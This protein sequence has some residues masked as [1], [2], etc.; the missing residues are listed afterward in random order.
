MARTFAKLTALGDGGQ[1]PNTTTEIE[2]P[3]MPESLELAREAAYK[4]VAPLNLPDGVHIYQSVNP[5][6]IPFSFKLHAFDDEVTKGGGA[7][8]LLKLAALLHAIMLPIR[9]GANPGVSQAPANASTTNGV[10]NFSP[11]LIGAANQLAFE[12]AQALANPQN[13]VLSNAAAG[14]ALTA[15]TLSSSEGIGIAAPAVC[16]LQLISSGDISTLSGGSTNV[17]RNDLNLC[18]LDCIGYVRSVNVKLKAPWL[19]ASDGTFNL[20]SSAEYSF[21]FVHAPGY[22]N[23]FSK[24]GSSTDFAKLADTQVF[25]ADMAGRFLGQKDKSGVIAP[26]AI[27]GI[28]TG[29]ASAPLPFVASPLN[30]GTNLL[31]PAV[32]FNA[33]TGR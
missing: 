24:F 6:T 29:A 7:A 17:L 26:E 10:P 30:P 27:K 22:R 20:P 3:C 21:V 19:Y 32:P 11:L 18:F 2:F 1:F 13:Q 14:E 33:T 16:R 23:R 31:S 4:V 9:D 25:A 8:Y 28:F 15:K 5:L 12:R